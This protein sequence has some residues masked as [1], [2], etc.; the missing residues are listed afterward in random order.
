MRRSLSPIMLIALFLAGCATPQPTL[1]PGEDA[2]ELAA[3]I[4]ARGQAGAPPTNEQEPAAE[5]E[6]TD[7]R[8]APIL[9]TSLRVGETCLLFGGLGALAALGK[10]RLYGLDCNRA[11]GEIW[12]DR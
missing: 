8:L 6:S 10:G 3:K 9:I 1:P 7:S 2:Q 5:P 11:I 12:A 4:A